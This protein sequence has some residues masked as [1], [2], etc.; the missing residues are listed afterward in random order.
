MQLP[1][2]LV[3]FKLKEKNKSTVKKFSY[4]LIFQKI[5]L[6]GPNIKH[7]LIFYHTSRKGNPLKTS[8]MSKNG[9][10][11]KLL[12]FWEMDLLSPCFRIKKIPSKKVLVYS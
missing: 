8:Y 6:S 1:G 9:N 5:E 2:P 12:I 11:K 10:P 4:F 3:K 7:F